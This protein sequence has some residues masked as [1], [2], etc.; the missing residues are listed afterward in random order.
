MARGEPCPG[1]CGGVCVCV[2]GGLPGPVPSPLLSPRVPAV[3]VCGSAGGG[4]RGDDDDPPG[5]ARRPAAL[6]GAAPGRAW[7]SGG[8]GLGLRRGGGGEAARAWVPA[9]KTLQDSSTPP[10]PPHPP[11]RWLGPPSGG[12]VFKLF[13]SR[14]KLIVPVYALKPNQPSKTAKFSVIIFLPLK[15]PI[16]L[17]IPRSR[18]AERRPRRPAGAR[19]GRVGGRRANCCSRPFPSGFTSRERAARGGRSPCPAVPKSRSPE[20]AVFVG[21]P[22][23]VL[24]SWGSHPGL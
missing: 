24:R 20:R 11:S 16:L 18:G 6:G 2:G 17:R 15:L 12:P 3:R 7:G 10:T 4:G 9:W 19:R 5:A 23:W 21:D 13:P 22:C 8:L 14:G 1:V